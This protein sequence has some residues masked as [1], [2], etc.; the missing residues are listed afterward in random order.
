MWEY[1]RLNEIVAGQTVICAASNVDTAHLDGIVIRFNSDDL[2]ADIWV[3]SFW[4]PPKPQIIS[5]AKLCC[6]GV[7][8]SRELFSDFGWDKNFAED[9]NKNANSFTPEFIHRAHWQELSIAMPVYPLSG[10][11]IL[12]MLQSTQMT[13]CLIIGYNFYL[14]RSHELWSRYHGAHDLFEAAV[15][16]GGLLESD[17]RFCWQGDRPFEAVKDAVARMV[18]ASAHG[19]SERRKAAL[20]KAQ[21]ELADISERLRLAASWNA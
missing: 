14:N 1:P 5:S 8:Q 19:Q 18:I 21:V 10:M 9:A 12:S 20:L 15:W 3:S 6:G 7:P 4:E 17:K 2:P 13:R 11:A 16:L